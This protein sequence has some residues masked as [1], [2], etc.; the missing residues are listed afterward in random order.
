MPGRKKIK[1]IYSG[2][3]HAFAVDTDGAVWAWGLNNYGQTGVYSD[4]GSDPLLTIPSPMIVD[5]LSEYDVAHMASGSCH[6][7]VV[8]R[9]GDLL[10]WGR[11]DAHQAGA[12]R[13]KVVDQDIIK[14]VAGKDRILITPTKIS[15]QKFATVECGLEHSIAIDTD[16]A[17]WSWGF[18]EMFQVGH[19]P[20]SR[21]IEEPTKIENSKTKLVFLKAASCGGNFSLIAGVPHED[22]E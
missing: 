3:Y 22:N 15:E 17:A 18:G 10:C 13:S 2:H 19:G 9:D 4:N 7:A 12:S 21:D 14:D 5:K 6:T 8:T 20:P 1:A 16:G 11:M